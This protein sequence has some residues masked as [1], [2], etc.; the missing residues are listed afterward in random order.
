MFVDDGILQKFD[1]GMFAYTF[2][3]PG[4]Y[5]ITL[6]ISDPAGNW[7]TDS[8][9]MRVLDVTR[10]AANAGEDK[11]AKVGESVAFDAGASSDNV[12]IVSY[13]WDFGD[14]S[15][16]TGVMVTHSYM[17]SGIYLVRVT[18]TDSA[19]NSASHVVSVVVTLPEGGEET[20]A[21]NQSSLF[22][23]LGVVFIIA[24]VAAFLVAKRR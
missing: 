22:W 10:P 4:S 11:I 9:T 18:V 19:S 12:G 1:T 5:L 16:A 6:N 14:G 7:A 23:F 20:Y 8:V 15:T 24:V 3:T 13:E 17:T 2:E 21:Q